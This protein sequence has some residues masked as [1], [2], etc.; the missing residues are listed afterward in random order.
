MTNTIRSLSEW[1]CIKNRPRKFEEIKALMSS[2]MTS[3]YSGGLLYEY[4]VE[5]NDYGIVTL[6][7]NTVE[8]SKEFNLY[9]QALKNNPAPTGSGGAA[10]TTHAVD[11][12][13]SASNWNVD[14]SEVP[15]MPSEA[16]DY[17]KKGA[18]DGPGLDGKGSQLDTDSG[19]ATASTTGGEVSPTGTA[20]ASEEGDDSAGVSVQV[21]MA[22]FVVTGLTL[23]F[24]LFGT[25][26]L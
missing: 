23:G 15:V 3:V 2:E 19:T 1:G 10:S 26:L 24:T 21:G 16:E 14:P 18:G 5:D 17:M 22:P 12:P 11:C 13:K 6:N 25:L 20:S 7:K 8:K 9:A 4:S